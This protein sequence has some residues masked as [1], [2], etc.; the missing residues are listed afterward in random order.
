[1]PLFATT[2]VSYNTFL[3]RNTNVRHNG[4]R[5]GQSNGRSQAT[6]NVD[7]GPSDQI[8]IPDHNLTEYSWWRASTGTIK[9]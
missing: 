5:G 2:L 1:M 3:M 8:T 7:L 4:T 6:R 9:V